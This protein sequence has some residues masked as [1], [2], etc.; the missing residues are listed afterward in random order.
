MPFPN[1]LVPWPVLVLVLGVVVLVVCVAVVHLGSKPSNRSFPLVANAA[2]LVFFMPHAA[3]ALTTNEQDHQHGKA[4]SLRMFRLPLLVIVGV[5]VLPGPP[6]SWIRAACCLGRRMLLLHDDQN[7][8]PPLPL[9]TLTHR[10]CS[11][12]RRQAARRKRRVESSGRLVV[13]GGPST[14]RQALLWL[15]VAGVEKEEGRLAKPAHTQG[16]ARTQTRGGPIPE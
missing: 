1:R 12:C 6:A 5:V 14:R 11:W 3:I 4:L 13:S 8:K 9:F 10:A 16:R 15:S 7:T 2:A